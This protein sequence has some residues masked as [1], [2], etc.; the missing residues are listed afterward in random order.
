[1]D[2]ADQFFVVTTLLVVALVLVGIVVAFV[3]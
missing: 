1:M 3:S 2:A